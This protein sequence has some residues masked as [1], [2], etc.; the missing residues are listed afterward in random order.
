MRLFTRRN[1]WY[2]AALLAA[3]AALGCWS[4]AHGNVIFGA[5]MMWS[6]GVNTVFLMNPSIAPEVP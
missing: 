5:F 4:F 6:G 1:P 3:Q 2:T